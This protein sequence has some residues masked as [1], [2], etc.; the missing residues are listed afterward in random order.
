VR[1]IPAGRFKATCLA[2]LDEVES[3]REPVVVTK[4]GRPVARIM[5]MPLESRDPIFG[6]YRGK[7]DIVGDVISPL[8]SD[9]ENEEFFE[10]S[11]RQLG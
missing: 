7:L 9:E 1:T 3:K 2:L 5:P 10:R 11:A 4:K 6:F 8:Y